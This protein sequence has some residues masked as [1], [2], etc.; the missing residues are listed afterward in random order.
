ML[1]SLVLLSFLSLGQA[2]YGPKSEVKHVDEKQFKSEVLQHKGPLDTDSSPYLSQYYIGIVIVE[3]YAPWC[4]HCKALAP[5]YEKAASILN[6]VVKVVAVDATQNEKLAQQYQIQGFPTIKVFGADKKSP[7][8]YQGPRTADAI[9]TEG[10]KSANK[11]VK[12]RKGG[13]SSKSSG[14][15][16]KK[17]KDKKKKKSNEVVELNDVNFEALVIESNEPWLVEFYAP[18]VRKNYI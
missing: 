13:K 3:F 2:L 4:G 16:E 11:L 7:M 8:D 5:E 9:V 15:T 12:D 14:G 1:L 17:P 10:M 6:G 18:W